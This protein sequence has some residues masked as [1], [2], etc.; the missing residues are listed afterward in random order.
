MAV[1]GQHDP[2]I[3]L[4]GPLVG[5][6]EM[7]VDRQRRRAVGQDGQ[8]ES[9]GE[10]CR[11][12]EPEPPPPDRDEQVNRGGQD[13]DLADL[14][15]R[16]GGAERQ[17]ARDEHPR[18][19]PALP[20]QDDQ[21]R[22]Y[23]CLEQDVGHDALLHL[24]LVAIEQNGRRGKS[25]KHAGS[26]AAQQHDVQSHGHSQAEQVLHGGD[27]VQVAHEKDGLQQDPVAKGVVAA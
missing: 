15:D 23:E 1:G 10:H 25:R 4:V 21:P 16:G 27:H 7:P 9:G 5:E 22:Y 24:E 20:E 11:L 12:S 2:A 14:P 17:P 26:A 6:P 18:P 13:E 19:G 3:Q 8:Q